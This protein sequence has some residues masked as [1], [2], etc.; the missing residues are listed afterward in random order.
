[1]NETGHA[2]QSCL[3]LNK[4]L[5]LQGYSDPMTSAAIENC[6]QKL[7]LGLNVL[8]TAPYFLRRI[9]G[10]IIMSIRYRGAKVS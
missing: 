1:M 5:S 7:S 10:G 8:P 3:T 4:N 9:E 2:E 6:C